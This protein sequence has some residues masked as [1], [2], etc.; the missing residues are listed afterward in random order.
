MGTDVSADDGVEQRRA[1]SGSE[2]SETGPRLL[3][4]FRVFSP[5]VS[6]SNPTSFVASPALSAPLHP[7]PLCSPLPLCQIAGVQNNELLSLCFAW[8]PATGELISTF[9]A[10]A[11]SVWD[12]LP[13]SPSAESILLYLTSAGR[14]QIYLD[15]GPLRRGRDASDT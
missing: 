14:W 2:F 6:K 9:Q 3:I 8:L 13:I 11:S 12:P 5:S 4:L 1:R 7:S 10:S 15:T